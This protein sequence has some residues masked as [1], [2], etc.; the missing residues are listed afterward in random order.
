[1]NCRQPDCGGTIE[2]GY[3]NECGLAP[4]SDLSPARSVR[5]TVSLTAGTSRRRIATGV[6]TSRR[7]RLGAGL[8]E[9]PRLADHDP[10]AEIL[11]DPHIEEGKRFCRGPS[12]GAPVGR[13]RDGAP[14]RSEGFCPR[15]GQPFSFRPSLAKG[16]LVGGQYEV[17]GSIAHGGLGWIYLARD[18]HVHD[19]WVVLKGLLN[20]SDPDAVAAALAERRF[21]AEVDDHRIV[22]IIN[23]VEHDSQGYIV[24]EHVPGT[25]LRKLL[26]DRRAANGDVPD[27]LPAA[28]AIA[29]LVEILPAFSYLHGR[30][31]LFCDFKPDNMMQTGESV[32]LIDLGGVYR[33]DDPT[34]A[35]YGTRGYQA[36]EIADTGPT[37]AS[38]LYTVG[39][40]LAVLCTAFPGYQERFEF[41]I[42]RPE[43]EPLFGTY[44]SL[45]RFL[46]RATAPDPDDRFQSAD[47]MQEQLF[48]VLR[49]IVAVETGAASPALS[50]LFTGELSADLD[51]P[52]W[53]GLPSLLV[54]TTDAAA[55]WLASIPAVSPEEALTLLDAAPE[56]TVE[57]RLRSLRELLLA[58]RFDDARAV[59]DLIAADDPW[60]WR[61]HWYRGLL[62][63]A[64]DT[65]DDAVVDLHAVYLAVPGELAPKLALATAH[66][67]AGRDAVAMAWYEVVAMT[68]PSMT[69]AAFGLAGCALSAGD[70]RRAL[71]ALDRVPASSRSF[72]A[73]Q[74]AKAEIL[75]GESPP[76]REDVVAA[77]LIVDRFPPGDPARRRLSILTLEH[78]LAVVQRDGDGPGV[79]LG[80]ELTENSL[81]IGLEATYRD[82]ARHALD[83]DARIEL[84][85]R[86]NQVR[87][88]TIW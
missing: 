67:L 53:Q 13:G 7:G 33:V 48:G 19:K 41:S 23:F 24:M 32:K 6:V 26:D 76:D 16:D 84:V 27:P 4:E 14:G 8:V 73:A 17:A 34:S 22:R 60:E 74:A 78:A 82:A 72:T 88:R 64:L 52:D 61:A 43:E 2:D 44:D 66:Q 11:V 50:S 62:A 29:Y 31:L 20:G 51:R 28:H 71:G 5:G 58:A 25:S 3:C 45:Y 59:A 75:L 39:R 70:R 86:A 12:C 40:T 54:D 46:L 85:D 10:E 83:P 57:V 30:G 81:R 9:I 55:G 77:A 42:P 18:K 63:L 1:V 56:V 49:E 21:L 69:R 15:C 47:E 80:C 35:I 36:P 38:D 87:P 65:P 79:V 68:D 37:V